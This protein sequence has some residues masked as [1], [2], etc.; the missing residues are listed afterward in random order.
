MINN[1]NDFTNTIQEPSTPSST[2]RMA[3]V[4]Q[5]SSGSA[6]ITFYG[7]ETQRSKSCKYLASYTPAVN[8]V[9]VCAKINNTY[10]ILGRVD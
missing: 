9:V 6:F 2:F 5:A 3:T 4:T 8:D 10:I 1:A 7:E